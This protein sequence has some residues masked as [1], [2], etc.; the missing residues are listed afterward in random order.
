MNLSV[1]FRELWQSWRASLRRPGFVLLAGLTLALGLGLSVAMF[2]LVN[3]LVLAPL[4][5]PQAKQLVV[6]GPTDGAGHFTE[7]PARWYPMLHDVSAL[8]STGYSVSWG[9]EV[10]VATAGAPVMVTALSVS[11]H[12]LSTLGVRM[13]LGRNFT[14]A[15][16]T[17]HGPR[18]VI[19]TYGFWQGH[20]A[21]LHDV[22]GRTLMIDGVSTTI[23]GVLPARFRMPEPFALMLPESLDTAQ[24]LNSNLVVLGRL[25]PGISLSNASAQIDARLQRWLPAHGESLARHPHA[26][27]TLLSSNMVAGY[28]E[29]LVFILRCNLALLALAGVN[30]ANLMLQRAVAHGHSQAIRAALGASSLRTVLPIMGEAILVGVLGTALGL[31]I[32]ALCL[33]WANANVMRPEWFGFITHVS[34]QPLAVAYCATASALVMF[35]AASVGLWRARNQHA[36]REL[37]TGGRGGQTV[38]SGRLSKALVILQA[39]LATFLLIYSFLFAL[40]EIIINRAP[41][42]FS[43]DHVLTATIHPPRSQYPDT[44]A[45][46][47]L[48]QRALD[49]LRA[50][51]GI[52]AAGIM[53]G[54]PLAS[55]VTLKFQRGTAPPFAAQYQFV[56]PDAFK[57][58]QIPLLAGRGF[59]A[60]DRAGAEPVAIVNTSFQKKYFTAG[61]LDHRL[62]LILHHV[63]LPTQ[64]L[65]IVGEV[66][67]VHVWGPGSPPPPI[68]YVPMAQVPNGL[69]DVLRQYGSLHIMART[70]GVP[71]NYLSNVKNVL[72]QVAPGLALLHLRPLAGRVNEF[73]AANR[74]LTMIFG[75][76]ACVALSLSSL[77]LFAVVNTSATART[78]EWGVRA[79]LGASPA[80]LF[81]AVLRVGL[82]QAGI[83]IMAGLVLGWGVTTFLGGVQINSASAGV[84]TI[85][86]SPLVLS[87][88]VTLLLS[89]ALLACLAPALRAAH[90]PPVA[91][92]SDD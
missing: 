27:A 64:H 52:M 82:I 25:K 41:L 79:A 58:L 87:S 86:A 53:N 84:D 35:F 21:G 12:Y 43:Y 65:R 89:A 88:L 57:T 3:T 62:D 33:R 90:T 66:G 29:M 72:G 92:L 11:Q 23:I 20:Y 49:R 51:P 77:G 24:R 76:I 4:P 10:N 50:Q 71:E 73:F 15:E 6:I 68:V 13:A 83:G 45:L 28:A 56:T 67:A 37:V 39:T 32:A 18:V 81:W 69:M 2:A 31:A 60:S 9:T 80:R 16:T 34:I 91:A 14:A 54:S 59:D 17:V 22:L 36:V 44:S 30:I 8:Q 47:A 19:L 78:R 61:A 26:S 74:M 55:A 38:A 7:M 75:F 40:T 63:D 70:R 48:G 85:F 1:V 5:Y 46:E 42:G